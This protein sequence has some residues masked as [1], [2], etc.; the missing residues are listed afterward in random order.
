MRGEYGEGEARPQGGGGLECRGREEAETEVERIGGSG[1][2]E[3]W[4]E[5]SL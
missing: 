4:R 1:R 2:K 3:W 5:L